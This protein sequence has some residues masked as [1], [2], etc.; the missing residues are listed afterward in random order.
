[1]K[2]YQPSAKDIKRK[3]YL[4]DAKDQILGRFASKIAKKLIGKHKVDYAPNLDMGDIVVVI[5]AKDIKV[6]G[7]KEKQKVYYKHSGYPGGFRE[8]KYKKLL[9]ENP[10]RIIELAVKRMLP[11]NRLQKKR[12]AR[13]KVFADAKHG[14]D[15]IEFANVDR[16]KK[17]K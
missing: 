5:N 3:W 15:K 16:K 9:E 10:A 14:Y 8:I 17:D 12:L 4:F 7:R 11:A 1:M 2:T 13:L 6:T